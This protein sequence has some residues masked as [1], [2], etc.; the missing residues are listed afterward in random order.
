MVHSRVFKNASPFTDTTI[1][2]VPYTKTVVPKK[3]LLLFRASKVALGSLQELPHWSLHSFKN[4]IPSRS[5]R[6]R[7]CDITRT[8]HSSECIH[9]GTELNIDSPVDHLGKSTECVGGIQNGWEVWTC[10]SWNRA[11]YWPVV[12]DP[13]TN[14]EHADRIQNHQE[15]WT[16]LSWNRDKYWL[17]CWSGTSTVCVDGIQC[18]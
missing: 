11:K 14:T 13:G 4:A 2:K 3:V 1:L 18:G 9:C 7:S 17:A 5:R 8:K 16:R 15:L 12:D 10:S 6:A